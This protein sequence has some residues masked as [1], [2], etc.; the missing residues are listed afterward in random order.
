MGTL[1]N[2]IFLILVVVFIVTIPIVIPQFIDAQ[3]TYVPIS[4]IPN[5]TEEG[6]NLNLENYLNNAFTFALGIATI[7]AI[8]KIALGGIKYM[9][10][11]SPGGT[12]DAKGTIWSAIIGLLLI[13]TTFII[14]KQIN[15]DI[16]KLDIGGS[17]QTPPEASAGQ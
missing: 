3:K 7:L 16:L 6:N 8:I 5:L 14:L 4:P 11:K 9:M 17:I 13:L 15:P 12:E 1:F 10:S 2:K